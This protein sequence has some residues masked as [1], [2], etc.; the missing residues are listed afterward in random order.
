MSTARRVSPTWDES[1]WRKCKKC[2]KPSKSTYVD[3]G[4]CI[5][6]DIKEKE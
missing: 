4:L 5:Q 1:K 3:S 2:G 6:C